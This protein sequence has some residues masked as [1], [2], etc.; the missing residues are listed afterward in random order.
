[1]ELRFYAL[2]VERKLRLVKQEIRKTAHA[3]FILRAQEEPTRE[4]ALRWRDEAVTLV[5]RIAGVPAEF[6]FIHCTEGVGKIDLHQNEDVRRYL[7][8][9]A[10]HL[11]ELARN[12]DA[13]AEGM[14]VWYVS[15]RFLRVYR[16]NARQHPQIR[17]KFSERN[18]VDDI[19]NSPCHGRGRWKRR[20]R[21]TQDRYQQ[22]IAH[23]TPI[24]CSR[25]HSVVVYN[26]PG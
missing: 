10:S 3:G 16:V 1:M 6:D 12:M 17:L 26:P 9:H 11:K 22:N 24:S 4:E 20:K 15:P 2:E 8:V 23:R 13:A 19:L 18:L 21:K 25:F 14:P 5:K 7:Y